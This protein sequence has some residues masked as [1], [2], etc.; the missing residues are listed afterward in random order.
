M[1]NL[2]TDEQS[3]NLYKELNVERTANP[4]INSLRDVHSVVALGHGLYVEFERENSVL[5]VTFQLMDNN[6]DNVNEFTELSDECE[7]AVDDV[8]SFLETILKDEIINGPYGAEERM[9]QFVDEPPYRATI[10]IPFDSDAV[11][12]ETVEYEITIM[13]GTSTV[14]VPKRR[15][16]NDEVDEYLENIWWRGI[17]HRDKIEKMGGDSWN[18]TDKEYQQSEN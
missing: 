16:E 10:T 12:I 11:D 3:Q 2:L 6:G 17:R 4:D 13:E 5:A 15:V 14:D 7:M 1:Y 18:L 8:F 9:M